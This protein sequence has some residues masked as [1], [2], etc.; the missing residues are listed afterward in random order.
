MSKSP[1]TARLGSYQEKERKQRQQ[2][3][4]LFPWVFF[5][6]CG[7]AASRYVPGRQP[8]RFAYGSSRAAGAANVNGEIFRI[9]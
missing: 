2:Q 3:R 6:T 4:A 1:L 7:V 8:H 5:A 9:V